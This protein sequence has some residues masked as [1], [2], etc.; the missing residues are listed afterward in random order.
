M[1]QVITFNIDIDKIDWNRVYTSPKTGKRYI[2]LIF[3]MSDEPDQYQQ[4]GMVKQQQTKE[5]RQAN[6]P[7]LPI[8]GNGKRISGGPQATQHAGYPPQYQQ[9]PGYPP[10]YPPQP[11]YQQA[12]PASYPP[13]QQA[14]PV[15]QQQVY[16]PQQ[17]QLYGPPP[18]QEQQQQYYGPPQQ[19]QGPPPQQ[20]QPT[21]SV[22]Y[23]APPKKEDLPF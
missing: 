16:P 15:Q 1:S 7:Q 8:L 13:Q 12:P 14:P 6:A 11:Q 5:E 2:D 19:Q 21:G 4:I 18:A 20:Q 17:Q 22:P 10:S 3:F 9:A 23:G